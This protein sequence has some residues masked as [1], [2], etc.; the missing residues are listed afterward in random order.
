MTDYGLYVYGKAGE[1][2]ISTQ[3]SGVED[4]PTADNG[5]TNRAFQ[6]MKQ[7]NICFYPKGVPHSMINPRSDAPELDPYWVPMLESDS[8]AFITK[9]TP[10]QTEGTSKEYGHPLCKS[11]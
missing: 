8:I 2:Q 6:K 7:A 4:D 9:G 3:I 10:F 11:R 5:Q 1:I